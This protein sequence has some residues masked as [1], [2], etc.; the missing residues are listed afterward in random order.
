MEG[1]LGPPECCSLASAPGRPPRVGPDEFGAG[2]PD[3]SVASICSAAGESL[4]TKIVTAIRQADALVPLWSAA[5]SQA[6]WVCQEI[7]IATDA[8]RLI[9]PGLLSPEAGLPSFLADTKYLSACGDLQ[10]ALAQLA[11]L[12]A[13]HVRTKASNEQAKTFAVLAAFVALL[14]IVRE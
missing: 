7:G 5:S 8:N 14:F 10:T 9:I 6:E 1:R 13:G 4:R 11:E 2:C 3:P 12:V